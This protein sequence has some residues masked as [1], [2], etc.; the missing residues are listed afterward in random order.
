[1]TGHGKEFVESIEFVG[2]IESRAEKCLKCLWCAKM[3]K[4][5][6]NKIWRK[7]QGILSKAR[8][9]FFHILLSFQF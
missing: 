3:P 8:I 1:M 9:Y 6:K 7:V 5:E 4:I 2:S